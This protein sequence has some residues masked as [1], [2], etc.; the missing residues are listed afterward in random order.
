MPSAFRAESRSVRRFVGL[1]S[2][3]K[4]NLWPAVDAILAEH[5]ADA[6]EIGDQIVLGALND[7]LIKLIVAGRYADVHGLMGKLLGLDGQERKPGAR[8]DGHF[9]G[10]KSLPN[11][12]ASAR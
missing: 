3:E 7:V 6:Q 5:R 9:Q 12:E 8:V 2:I 10:R 11:A 1:P 4:A